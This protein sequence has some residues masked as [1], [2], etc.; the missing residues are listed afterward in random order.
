M[1]H[2]RATMAN[3]IHRR[4]VR[5]SPDLLIVGAGR[6]GWKELL[7]SPGPARDSLQAVPFVREPTI[8][9]CKSTREVCQ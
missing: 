4:D 8:S 9:V 7:R 2:E 5:L 6:R 3:L 1:M